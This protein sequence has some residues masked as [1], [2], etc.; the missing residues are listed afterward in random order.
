MTVTIFCFG[1][2]IVINRAQSCQTLYLRNKCPV[3]SNGENEWEVVS[4]R[5][6]WRGD[7]RSVCEA[8]F[9]VLSVELE[10]PSGPAVYV[11]SSCVGHDGGWPGQAPRS[12]TLHV[13]ARTFQGSRRAERSVLPHPSPQ[14]ARLPSCLVSQKLLRKSLPVMEAF[15]PT[16]VLRGLQS[17]AFALL[18]AVTAA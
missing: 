12:S 17:A 10:V 4:R 18:T 14:A 6:G 5:Q 13:C 3:V 8:L 15:C 1:F 16:P 7:R 2:K 11:L 9:A